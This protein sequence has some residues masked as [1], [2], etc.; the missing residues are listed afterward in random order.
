[1]VLVNRVCGE[2]AVLSG[3]EQETQTQLAAAVKSANRWL[4]EQTE[5]RRDLFFRL[6]QAVN[7]QR[8]RQVRRLLAHVNAAASRDRTEA[9]NAIVD[10]A[11]G[12][13]A[14]LARGQQAGTVAGRAV[15]NGSG[16]GHERV[17]NILGNLRRRD[18]DVMRAEMRSLVKVLIRAATDAGDRVTASQAA[19]IAD[20]QERAGPDKP[21]PAAGSLAEA[22]A[23]AAQPSSRD[24]VTASDVN[25]VVQRRTWTPLAPPSRAR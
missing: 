6:N 20:W 18:G 2:I 10:A 15:A 21:V 24:A 7:S 14:A 22:R 3:L 5:A 19:E 4:E 17:H 11:A 1:M 25:R 9:E 13:L 23:A 16:A 12:H 8:T